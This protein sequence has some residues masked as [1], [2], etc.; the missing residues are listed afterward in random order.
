MATLEEKQ[1]A[2]DILLKMIDNQNLNYSDFPDFHENE[3]TGLNLALAA[4]Q[5]ILKTIAGN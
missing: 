2:K 3:K 5:K 1:L 4:Y